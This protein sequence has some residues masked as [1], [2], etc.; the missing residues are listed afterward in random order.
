MQ[1]YFIGGEGSHLT[2][3]LFADPLVN[4]ALRNED[5]QVKL[6]GWLPCDL[7][8]GDAITM[9]VIKPNPYRATYFVRTNFSG[10]GSM[11]S[12]NRQPY[13]RD[14]LTNNRLY[15]CVVEA[16]PGVAVEVDFELPSGIKRV[17]A[18]GGYARS[19]NPWKGSLNK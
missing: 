18:L 5:K 10:G 16:G 1:I 12:R 6:I 7:G 19:W 9:R 15:I 14:G 17:Y 8:N 2:K 4:A 13:L 11:Y 3:S